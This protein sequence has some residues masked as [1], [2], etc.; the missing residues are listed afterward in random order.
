LEIWILSG[1]T[2]G[3]ET[4]LLLTKNILSRNKWGIS[5]VG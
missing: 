1:L 2:R 4:Y 5:S 3:F